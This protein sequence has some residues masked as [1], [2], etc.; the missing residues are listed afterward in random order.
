[1]EEEYTKLGMLSTYTFAQLPPDRKAISCKWVFVCKYGP[2]GEISKYKAHLIVR[3]FL[4]RQGKDFKETFAPMAK[5]A[6]MRIVCC[7][8][9]FENELMKGGAQGAH[10]HKRNNYCF[11]LFLFYLYTI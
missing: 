8:A 3:G 7:I 1:M 2:N 11:I 6:S 4:Q 5:M 10:G 9:A